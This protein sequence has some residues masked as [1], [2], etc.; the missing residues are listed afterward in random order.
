MI[1][2]TSI[3]ESGGCSAQTTAVKSPRTPIKIAIAS[4]KGGT[5]KSFVA[6]NLACTLVQDHDVTLLDCDVEEPNLHLYFSCPWN[7]EEVTQP[8]PQI[9]TEICTRCGRCGEVCQYGA[10]TVLPDRVLFLPDLCH[11]CGACVTS[12]PEGAICEGNRTIGKIRTGQPFPGLT[13]ISGVLNEGEVSTPRLIRKVKEAAQGHPLVISDG[14]PGS[15]CPVIETLEGNDFCILVTESTPF[16]LHD[17]Q[18]AAQVTK[19]LEIP[20]GV[21]I[22]RSTGQNEMIADFCTSTNIPILGTIP[23]DREIARL[24]GQGDILIQKRPD[25]GGFFRTLF[26]RCIGIYGGVR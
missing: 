19:K 7:E 6:L 22:N 17:L 2:G 3:S 1:T 4:G 5:G 21:V 13:L 16:G 18:K 20:T 26:D 9:D 10:M 15:A 23:F 8:V 11:A 25:W 24:H 14:P 12:C